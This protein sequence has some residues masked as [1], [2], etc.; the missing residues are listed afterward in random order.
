MHARLHRNMCIESSD[1]ELPARNCNKL[2]IPKQMNRDCFG[3]SE[4]PL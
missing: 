1:F 2:W 4:D 3:L